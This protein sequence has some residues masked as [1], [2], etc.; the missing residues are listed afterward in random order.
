MKTITSLKKALLAILCLASTSVMAETY[1]YEFTS[2]VWSENGAQTLNGVE[3]NLQTDAGYFGFDTNN[4]TDRG[5]QFGSSKKPSTYVTLSTSD[6]AGYISSIVV[7][8]AGANGI[9]ATLSVTIGGSAF[10]SSQAITNTTTPY[11]FLGNGNGEIVL[12]WDN[13]SSIALYIKSIEITYSDQPVAV[14]PPVVSVA[15]GRY[16]EAQN[17]EL[18]CA[19]TGAS[20]YYTLDGTEPS[21]SSTLYTG[22]INIA[23]TTTLKAIAIKDNN[24]SAVVTMNYTIITTTV[25]TIADFLAAEE[26]E[27]AYYELTG[28]ISNLKNTEYGNFDLVDATGTVYVYGLT[29]TMQTSNNKTF[30]SLNLVE[31]DNITIRGTRDSYNGEAQVGGPAYFVSKNENPSA[32][33]NNKVSSIR[34]DGQTIYNPENANIVVYSLVGTVVAEGNTDIDM[35]NQNSG[36][37]IVRA[38]KSVTKIVKQ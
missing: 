27:D 29:S 31:G 3:W 19:T 10:G 17:V 12:N 34:F 9:N 18:T 13:S 23:S 25:S 36:I 11:T 22:A 20:I 24:S 6:I 8:T 28:T 33:Q 26:S 7:N 1:T 21:A 30:A 4:T 16:T 2:K 14:L 37:Y 38:G 15:G 32:I 5:Q 35:S